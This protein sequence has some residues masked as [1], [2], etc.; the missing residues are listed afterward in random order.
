MLRVLKK[1]AP[2]WFE[3]TRD[4]GDD[5]DMEAYVDVEGNWDEIDENPNISAVVDDAAVDDAE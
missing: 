4:D 1:S 5:N 2:I 3:K